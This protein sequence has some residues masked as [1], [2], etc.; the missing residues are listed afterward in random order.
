MSLAELFT[1]FAMLSSLLLIG[2]GLFVMVK[3][4][5]VSMNA[6]PVKIRVRSRNVQ[7]RRDR[8]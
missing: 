3:N 4:L 5:A 7:E 6:R 2:A 8:R 1:G